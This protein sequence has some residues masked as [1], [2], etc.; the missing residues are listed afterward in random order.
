MEQK[1]T[2]LLKSMN[3]AANEQ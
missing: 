3:V 1:T 2:Q